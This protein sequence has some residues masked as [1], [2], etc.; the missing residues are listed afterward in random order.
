MG[1][2]NIA[3]SGMKAS[4]TNMEVISN[5]IANASTVGFKKSQASFSD[6]YASG[7]NIQP[8]LG[9][10]VTDIT[11]N[12][13]RGDVETTGTMSNMSIKNGSA[14]FIL[15]DTLSGL[16][17]Y[18]RAGQFQVDTDGYFVMNNQRLQGFPAKNNTILAPTVTDLQI[19]IDTSPASGTTTVSENINLD[20][21][22]VIPAGTFDSSD[23]STYNFRTNVQVYDSLGS[24]ATMSLFYIKTAS[25]TWSVRGEIGGASIGSATGINFTTT[26]A[27]APPAPTI[28][29]SYSPTTGAASPQAINLNLNKI[30]QYGS[31]STTIAP[32]TQN[33]YSTGTFGG[34]TI[35]D[36]GLVKV[37]YT[38]GQDSVAGQVA[39][40]TFQSPQ[41]L[42]Y[43]GN[44]SW[45]ASSDSGTALVNLSNSLGNITASS[46]E[47]SN[48]DLTDEM[49]NLIGAQHSF[50]A[51]AQ[52]EQ[53]YNEIMQTVMQL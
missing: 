14:F 36:N 20:A 32:T 40:A 6:L 33:G 19:P 24:P 38:N 12:F 35:D 7:G 45:T 27:L 2:G 9:V 52:V 29:L 42:S 1:I 3:N 48:V 26:G 43:N 39:L 5:N 13:S 41:G 17:T 18:S 37:Q 8:G 11:Q 31:K 4:M 23:A 22:A 34:Y 53:T 25:N 21:G 47:A 30:T 28:A 46:V 15:N 44:M 50:Q 51:N 49:V 10:N 16:T